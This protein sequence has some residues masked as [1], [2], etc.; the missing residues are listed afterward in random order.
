MGEQPPTLRDEGDTA[1]QHLLRSQPV[2]RL[3]IEDEQSLLDAAL[4]V[5]E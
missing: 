1:L 2:D 3:P 5:S 4:L